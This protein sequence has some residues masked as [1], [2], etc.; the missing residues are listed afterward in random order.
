MIKQ[1][2]MQKFEPLFTQTETAYSLYCH[3]TDYVQLNFNMLSITL[4][5]EDFIDFAQD[6][7][8]LPLFAAVQNQEKLIELLEGSDTAL[9]QMEMETL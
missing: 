6:P 8:S 2:K 5:K 9:L 4:S 3:D 1:P 7:L